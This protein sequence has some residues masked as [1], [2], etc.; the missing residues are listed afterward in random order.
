MSSVPDAL[1]RFEL[2]S[3]PDSDADSEIEGEFI[4]QWEDASESERDVILDAYSARYPHLAD[5]FNKLIAASAFL[6]PEADP[7]KLGSYRIIK[8]LAVGGM[9]KVYEAEDIVL[10]RRVAVKTIRTGRRANRATTRRFLREREALARLH[11][12]NIVPI[13]GAGEEA[14]LLYFAMPLLNGVTLADLVNTSR[15]AASR[16][17]STWEQLV[18]LASTRAHQEREYRKLTASLGCPPGKGETPSSS[19]PGETSDP[20]HAYLSLLPPDYLSRVALVVAEAANAVH[21]A[22]RNG[23]IHKDLKPSNLQIDSSSEMSH[24]WVLDLGLASF[25]NDAGDSA[26]PDSAQAAGRDTTAADDHTKGVGSLPYMAPEQILMDDVTAAMDSRLEE[27]PTIGP[28]TD[29][30][31]LGVTLYQLVSLRLPFP[32]RTREELAVSILSKDPLPLDKAIPSEL[33]A[34]CL[35]ALSKRAEQRY[36]T[37]AEFSADLHRWR[38]GEPT[39]AGQA[40]VLRRGLMWTKRNPSRAGLAATLTTIGV[41]L[42]VGIWYDEKARANALEVQT[43]EQQRELSTLRSSE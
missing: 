9:G 16:S 30:W 27:R 15:L 32:G 4:A 3:N 20:T 28:H 2:D 5:C 42:A 18:L 35:K 11:H 14:G 22:H 37:T 31:G 39:I 36:T 12:S 23:I 19:S 33:R 24:I 8:L 6:R 38:N 21:F 7:V 26:G 17:S 29:T 1:D 34:V 25:V 41:L 13:F 10:K 40:G 43:R